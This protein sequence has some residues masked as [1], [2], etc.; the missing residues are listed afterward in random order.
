MLGQP[1][2]QI[3]KNSY[4]SGALTTSGP[5]GG[6]VGSSSSGY[7]IDSFATGSVSYAS[8]G[9][10]VGGNIVQKL[11]NVYWD[12]FRTGKSNCYQSGSTGCTGK[13][14]G[15]SEPNYWFN[16]SVD[17][18]MDQ[19]NF[20][21]IWQTNVG[22]YPTL[23][24]VILDEITPVIPS[25]TDTT[26]SY[27]FFSNTAGAIT[28]GGDCTSATGTATIGSN[29]ITFDALSVAVHSNCTLAVGGVTMNIT[30][31]QIVSGFAGGA[32]TSGDPYQITTCAQL[33][34][35]DSYRTSYFI[36]NNAIDCA[37]A[38]FN[39]G[40][41]FLPVGTS[42]SK[43]TGGF[44]G[45]GYTISNLYIDRPLIDYVGLFGYVDGTDT[46][47]IKDV[48]LTGAD[49]TGKNYVGAL[50]GYLLDTIM[51]DA[52]SAGTVDGYSYV[53]GLLGYIDSTTVKACYSSATVAGYSLIG[54]LSSYLANASYLGFSYATGA[55]TGYS[56]AGGLLASTTGT[57]NT[58]YNCYATG[59]VSTS[60]GVTTSSQFGG[61]LGT[62][63]ASS[64]V[65]NSYA[66]G[67]TTSGSYAGGLIAAP[68]SNYTKDSFATGA[69]TTGSFQG[70]V[71]GSVT[72][73]SRNNVYWDIYRTSQSNC[74]QT[75]SVN[76]TGKN[77]GNADPNYWFNSSTNP[78]FNQWDFNTVWDTNAESYPTLQSVILEEVTQVAPATIDTTPN[79]TFFS[80]TAGAITYGGDCTSATGTAVVG[81][82][83]V[84][85][86]TL[87]AAVHSNCTLA[88]G[89]VTMNISPFEI[90]AGFAGGAG[91]SGN[92]YQITTC[93]QLQLMDSY[94]TSYFILNNNIDCAVAPFNTGVGFLP[95]GDATTKFSGGFNGADYTIDGLY[96]NRP[97]T[98]YVGLFGYA[99]GTDVQSIQDF[100][101]TNVNIT[102]YDY[103]GAAVGY[104]IDITVTKVGSLGAVTGNHYVGGLLGAISSTT[105]SNSFSSATVIGYGVYIGGLIG[106]S[107]SSAIT[108]N[109][110]A[111]GAVTGY[112]D[113]IGGLLGFLSS[114]TLTY[115]YA[116]G[117]VTATS[118]SSG[119]LIGSKSAGTLNNSYW[120]VTRTGKATCYNGGSTGCTAK[121]TAS[122]EPNYWFGN[123]ANAP[124]DSWDFVTTPIWYVVGGTYPALDP[125]PTI[126][127]TSTT[128]SGSEA[129]TAVN[130]EVSIDITWTD[131]VTVDYVVSGGTATGTGTDYTLA[132]GTATITAGST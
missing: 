126:Q 113:G 106:Y 129:T 97:A 45:A 127:F 103:V 105:A 72:S 10:A 7:I 124:M 59:A 82:N 41:G 34:L 32:G 20:D 60:S 47:Y 6:L 31:F 48:S 30:D 33:Q 87:S 80:D 51:V 39:T 61:L 2:A 86:S 77:S 91:T 90:I 78:P 26:P 9:G 99:D 63:G 118:G 92:P 131:N 19:W 95:I 74:Y 28:Y 50:A 56:G 69:V 104:D 84:T 62:A 89:G 36:L 14:S 81:N 75:A 110:Y 27:T 101:M 4:A 16:T 85:F 128:G 37:V 66:T 18:P 29:T 24:S 11:D 125:P 116:T 96:I 8:G 57:R 3:L 1:G 109:C 117:A 114:T 100:I 52:S 122:A 64:F 23:R 12:I 88:V 5:S 43:F 76:C 42:A 108:T 53:G 120:D 35:M 94:R 71:F 21:S 123:S 107:L 73:S 22:A 132:S 58:L 40:L 112:I 67:A 130:L 46:Q 119:G 25:A 93:A 121:N 79:Y 65:Y 44:D 54:G 83:T 49:I 17:A 68:T 38:P 111:T 70:G 98:D 13:N 15:N 55:I 102:G 115:S